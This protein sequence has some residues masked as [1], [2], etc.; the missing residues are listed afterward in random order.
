[1]D[2]GQ[3]LKELA[4]ELQMS[5]WPAERGKLDKKRGYSTHSRRYRQ[6]CECRFK[7]TVRVL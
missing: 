7:I 5:E 6:L 1:M 3:Y 2:I 4:S